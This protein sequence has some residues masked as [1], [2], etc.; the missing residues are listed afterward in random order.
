MSDLQ[1]LTTALQ[2]RYRIDRPLGAGGLATVYLA[3]DPK[4]DREVAPKVLRPVLG[5][6]LGPPL[7]RFTVHFFHE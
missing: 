3:T 4:H 2:E 1:R 5:G 7:R 6:V